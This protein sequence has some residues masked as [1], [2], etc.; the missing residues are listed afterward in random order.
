MRPVDTDPES[1]AVQMRV[2]ARMSPEA[3][4]LRAFELCECTRELAR[5]RIRAEHPELDRAGVRRELVRLLYGDL[6]PPER[7]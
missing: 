6:L 2:F 3:R 5:S 1:H 7:R 4:L